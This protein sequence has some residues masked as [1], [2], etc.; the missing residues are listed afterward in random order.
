MIFQ[1]FDRV[2]SE[3]KQKYIS[4]NKLKE[5]GNKLKKKIEEN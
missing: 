4:S 1:D 5:L 3:T 2:F